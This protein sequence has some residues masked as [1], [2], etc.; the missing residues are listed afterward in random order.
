MIEARNP[1]VRK[2]EGGPPRGMK[3]AFNQGMIRANPAYQKANGGS[4]FIQS[5][6][7]NS[8]S[9]GIIAFFL[10]YRERVYIGIG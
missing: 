1:I 2:M 4:A 6:D 8:A 3:W 10:P 5:M 7:D 9:A